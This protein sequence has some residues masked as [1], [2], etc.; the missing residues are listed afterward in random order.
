MTTT[1][2]V[3]FYYDPDHDTNDGRAWT[4]DDIDDLR[5]VLANGGTIEDAAVLLCRRA[6]KTMCAARPRTS[7]F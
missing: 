4:E 3:D 1:P 5:L 2:K 7:G 6:R